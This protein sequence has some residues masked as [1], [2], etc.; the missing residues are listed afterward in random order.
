M[1]S[2]HKKICFAYTGFGRIAYPFK[3]NHRE[4][5]YMHF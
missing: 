1:L 3:A 4:M 2:G 5:D